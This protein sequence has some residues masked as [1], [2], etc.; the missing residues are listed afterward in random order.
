M[1]VLET[2]KLIDGAQDSWVLH[3]G[4]TELPGIRERVPASVPEAAALQ[5]Q[6]C[7][8]NHIADACACKNIC[9]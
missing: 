9:K 3:R 4:I 5:V 2:V 8:L 7:H 1:G 6:P